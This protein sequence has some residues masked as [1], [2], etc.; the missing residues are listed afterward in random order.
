MKEH[1]ILMCSIAFILG[2]LVARMMRGNGLSVGAAQDNK[3]C[4]INT[5]TI[6]GS[7]TSLSCCKQY[8]L[9][10][11][12][13]NILPGDK[14][15][16]INKPDLPPGCFMRL[17]PRH[18]NDPGSG[19]QDMKS[20]GRYNTNASGTNKYNMVFPVKNPCNHFI[21]GTEP[22]GDPGPCAR[23][24]T[25]SCSSLKITVPTLAPG[26]NPN[27]YLNKECSKYYQKG[28]TNR[29]THVEAPSNQYCI[30][31]SKSCNKC[32]VDINGKA[33]KF[34]CEE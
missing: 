3:K 7:L 18:P 17:L 4:S 28:T 1:E 6:S 32:S 15:K 31:S 11:A 12:S 21:G 8:A 30:L 26:Q 20:V 9:T 13:D 27:D 25:E 10:A 34:C 33:T 22:H 24:E 23:N 2:Y 19:K 29:C 5:S 14:F 16:T